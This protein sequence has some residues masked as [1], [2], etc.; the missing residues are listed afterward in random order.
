MPIEMAKQLQ[1]NVSNNNKSKTVPSQELIFHHFAENK[2]QTQIVIN[3][4]I[5]LNRLQNSRFFSQN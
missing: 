2:S 3:T 1:N 5:M 4:C